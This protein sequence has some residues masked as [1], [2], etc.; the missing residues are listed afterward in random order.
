LADEDFQ[1]TAAKF[2][3]G[4][5]EDVGEILERYTSAVS[6]TAA[7]L[8]AMAT[9]QFEGMMAGNDVMFMVDTGYKL[10]LMSKEFFR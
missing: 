5:H 4:A 1:E 7:P 3:Y 9:G 10:N 8:F 2:L 6:L